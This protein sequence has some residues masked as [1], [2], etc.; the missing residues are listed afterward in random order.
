MAGR[1]SPEEIRRSMEANRAEL[2]LAVEK[3]RV[4]VAAAT[5]WRKQLRQNHEQ[6]VTA[7]AGLGFLLGGGVGGLVDLVFR[8]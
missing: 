4:E 3:L 7:A 1:R 8:R 2:G 5:D 6:A